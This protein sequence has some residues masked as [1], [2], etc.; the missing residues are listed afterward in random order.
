M[1][2]GT[3]QEGV[4]VQKWLRETETMVNKTK[5]GGGGVGDIEPMVKTTYQGG[6]ASKQWLKKNLQGRGDTEAMVR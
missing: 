3:Y 6:V 4:T 1:I 2:K 5:V